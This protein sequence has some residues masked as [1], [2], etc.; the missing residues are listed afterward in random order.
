M[1]EKA[2]EALTELTICPSKMFMLV[3]GLRIG[4]EEVEG[5]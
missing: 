5:G 3:G 2:V 1:I 4:D